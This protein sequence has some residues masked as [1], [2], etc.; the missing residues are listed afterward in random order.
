MPLPIADSAT[1]TN[2]TFS[3]PAPRDRTNT[4]IQANNRIDEETIQGLRDLGIRLTADRLANRPEP[5]LARARTITPLGSITFRL[6]LKTSV[7]MLVA[8]RNAFV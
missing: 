2:V 8:Q 7:D 1:P 5:I 3:N 6:Y 4:F